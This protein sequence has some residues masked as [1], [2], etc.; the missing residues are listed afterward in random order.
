MRLGK[1][2]ATAGLVALG[3]ADAVLIAFALRAGAGT[4]GP[5][6]AL[7]SPEPTAS[8]GASASSSPTASRAPSTTG[9]APSTS[10]SLS[11]SP[12][13]TD[14]G[15]LLLAAVDADTAWRV[16]GGTCDG[17]R[18]R[19]ERTDDGGA[20]WQDV[21]SPLPVITRIQPR[22]GGSAFVVG[23]NK[24]CEPALQSTQDG[25]RSWAHTAEPSLAW[26]VAAKD[27]STVNAPGAGTSRP[28]GKE[29][30]VLDLA[31]TG[32][33]GARVLC[34]GGRVLETADDGGSWD[35][36]GS[37]DAALAIAVSADDPSVTYAVRNGQVD[38]TGLDVLR[39][40][41]DDVLGCADVDATA[42]V[43][44]AASVAQD[45]WVWVGADDGVT[46]SEDLRDWRTASF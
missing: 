6:E 39:V 3:A 44:V 25:G 22:G 19:I 43:A 11:G 9:A 5:A 24:Q 29:S 14:A 32:N 45:G 4:G 8:H 36:L 2:A 26:F 15:P 42:T 23:A 33:D 20:T 18:A 21:D 35:E 37:V 16:H 13:G 31:P 1:R 27:R 7:P 34:E 28:C 10:S 40:T 17:D 41:T 12:A 30:D 38:C 46:R